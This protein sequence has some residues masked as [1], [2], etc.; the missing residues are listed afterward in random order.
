[1]LRTPTGKAIMAVLIGF[2]IATLF[3]KS[4]KDKKCLEFKGPS[5]DNIKE[6]IYRKGNKCYQFD[7]SEEKCDS[8]KKTVVIA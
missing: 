1:M 4:C 7:P 6:R 3:R 5:L 8:Q 2:G